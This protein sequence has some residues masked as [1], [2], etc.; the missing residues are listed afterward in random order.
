MEEK[1]VDVFKEGKDRMKIVHLAVDGEVIG[2][3]HLGSE[4]TPGD[5][6]RVVINLN[7]TLYGSNY[8]VGEIRGYGRAFIVVLNKTKE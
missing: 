3:V 7:P 1:V 8:K 5:P 4:G 2:T 6:N